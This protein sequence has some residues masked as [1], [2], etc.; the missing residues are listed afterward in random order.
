MLA[1]V[2]AFIEKRDP[3]ATKRE[4]ETGQR[5]YRERIGFLRQFKSNLEYEIGGHDELDQ[6]FL[7]KRVG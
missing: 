3:I 7:P 5:F 6:G 4:T 1:Y 2:R